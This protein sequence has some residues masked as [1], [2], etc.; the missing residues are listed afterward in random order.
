M[1]RGVLGVGGCVGDWEGDGVF[2]WGGSKVLLKL[3]TFCRLKSK[4]K[5]SKKTHFP[6]LWFSQKKKSCEIFLFEK[7]PIFSFRHILKDVFKTL[8]WGP[9]TVRKKY[10]VGSEIFPKRVFFLFSGKKVAKFF[11]WKNFRLFQFGT[12]QKMSSRLFCGEQKQS[13]KNIE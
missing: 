2:F 13:G 12:F 4:S 7:L 5:N 11:Y 9:E 1:G 10:R 3:S 6:H 8:L